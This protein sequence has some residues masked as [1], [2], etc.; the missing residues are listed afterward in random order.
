MLDLYT[1][2]TPNG[3]K[4]SIALEEL[5]LDYRVHR[6]FLGG[7]Q[8]TPEFTRLNPNRK[9]PVLVDDGL[10]VTESGAILIHLAE[11]AGKLLP[12]GPAARAA[13]IEMLMFQMASI[14]PML[15]Q[16]LVFRGPWRNRAPEVSNRYFQE[17]SRLY[18]V[19]NTRL[20]GRDY[21]AGDAFSIADIALLP[22]IRTGS[23]APFTADLPLD[24]NP[25]LKAWFERVMARP[26]VQK[27]LTIPEPFPPEKQFEGFI[28]ATV[29]LGDLHAA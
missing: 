28:K 16:L 20:A 23:L 10:V 13:V 18:G 19:L 27:G 5:G 26:A 3:L 29:G 25:H 4:I 2:A 21:L 7:E 15:G 22:W 1:D 6:V 24:A 17:A 11:K 12:A 14:G 8:K 9:I